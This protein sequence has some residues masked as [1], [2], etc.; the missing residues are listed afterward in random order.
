[1]TATLFYYYDPMCSWCWGYRPV[2]TAL[3]QHLPAEVSVVNILGGLAADSDEPMPLETQEAIQ[4]HWHKIHNLLGTEF[5][6]DFWQ[7]NKPK[8]ST[9]K[10]CR[11]VIAATNQNQ[12]GAMIKAIQQGYYLRA[13]N[14]S[15]TD[16]LIQLAKEI[17][18]IA[19]KFER[20]LESRETHKNLSEQIQFTR[21]SPI[22]GF[23]SLALSASSRGSELKPVKKDYH[24]YRVTLDHILE[25][26]KH[27]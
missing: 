16:V 9:Y 21:Q 26:L 14:P 13:M 11:A 4:G 18:L 25:L 10:A 22:S 24:D 12:E 27:W 8:R 1:M 5:N 7:K 15:E 3:K 20:D 6:F 17:G 23:P 2:W 19:I